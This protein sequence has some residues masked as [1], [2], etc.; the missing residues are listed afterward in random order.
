MKLVIIYVCIQKFIIE[1]ISVICDD[2]NIDIDM[3]HFML[4]RDCGKF[5]S[6]ASSR[7]SNAQDSNRHYPWVVRVT[8]SNAYL[9]NNEGACGGSVITKNSAITA[10]HCLC[11]A[12]TEKDYAAEKDIRDKLIVEVVKV[13]LKIS[14]IC[15]M[16]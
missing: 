3:D 9:E 6:I 12:T 2:G 1:N 4:E 13:K 7:I 8:R 14:S 11:G 16:K 10:A 5:P 15:Q